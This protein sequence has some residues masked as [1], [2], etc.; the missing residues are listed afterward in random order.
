MG[1]DCYG[2]LPPTYIDMA[3]CHHQLCTTNKLLQMLQVE[4]S[5]SDFNR[6]FMR[7]AIHLQMEMSDI[8]KF[9]LEVS[10]SLISQTL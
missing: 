4:A 10:F 3:P 7:S 5:Q 8:C 6:D 9:Q 1:L 2:I